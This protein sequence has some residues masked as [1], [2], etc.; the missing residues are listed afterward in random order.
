M[1]PLAASLL[2]VVL[3][4]ACGAEDQPTPAPSVDPTTAVATPEPTEMTSQPVE[5][6]TP[7]PVTTASP[8][9]PATSE[10]SAPAPDNIP[11][12]P[13]Q[14]GDYTYDGVDPHFGYYEVGGNAEAPIFQ[15]EYDPAAVY[16]EWM[17]SRDDEWMDDVWYCGST[18]LS[19]VC[20]TQIVPGQGGLVLLALGDQEEQI[21]S[22]AD[23]LLA[24]R[25]YEGFR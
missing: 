18:E 13:E 1:R 21:L 3:L 4:G 15:V 8:Q 14:V 7:D 22:F 12:F 25:P 20:E 9:T 2:A 19:R 23:D 11:P 16:G 17:G 6:K 10:S 24:V 5:T